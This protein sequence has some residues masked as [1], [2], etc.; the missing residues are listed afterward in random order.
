MRSSEQLATTGT[1]SNIRSPGQV[2]WVGSQQVTERLTRFPRV[3]GSSPTG[4]TKDQVSRLFHT[5]DG[6]LGTNVP[7]AFPRCHL[8]CHQET[9][10][11]EPLW[12][13]WSSVPGGNRRSRADAT[14]PSTARRPMYTS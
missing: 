13:P 2:G 7:E 11:N 12:V 4:P 8:S 9:T 14:E 1:E 5:T 6:S 10:V 3:V